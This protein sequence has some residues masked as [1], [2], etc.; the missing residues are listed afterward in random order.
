MNIS[1]ASDEIFPKQ[2]PQTAQPNRA[3]AGRTSKRSTSVLKGLGSH[4]NARV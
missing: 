1:G 3:R 2:R 4:K